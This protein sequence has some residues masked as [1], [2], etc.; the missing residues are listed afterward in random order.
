MLERRARVEVERQLLDEV[1]TEL[2]QTE[3]LHLAQLGG[4]ALDDV[5]V[6]PERAQSL[7]PADGP[8][9]GDLV[10]LHAQVEDVAVG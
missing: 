3:R 8:Q 4:H 5:V 7:H 9:V 1:V 10:V 6:R 2:Q